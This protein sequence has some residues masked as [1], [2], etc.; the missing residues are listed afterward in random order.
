MMNSITPELI[1]KACHG[2][3]ATETL[4]IKRSIDAVD[5]YEGSKTGIHWVRVT[6]LEEV[7]RP[8]VLDLHWNKDPGGT[9]ALSLVWF[10][11]GKKYGIHRVISCEVRKAIQRCWLLTLEV[12]AMFHVAKATE[13]EGCWPYGFTP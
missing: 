1:A 8:P 7:E 5:W 13:G 9:L 6:L 2:M 3:S 10:Q 11:G 4:L 12:R